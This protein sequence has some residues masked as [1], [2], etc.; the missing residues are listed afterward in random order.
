MYAHNNETTNLSCRAYV[1]N[2]TSENPLEPFQVSQALF[3]P[4]TTF[5]HKQIQFK[6]QKLT[7][8]KANNTSLMERL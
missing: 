4:I 5:T 3:M 2:V 6:E 8:R 1:E 7:S